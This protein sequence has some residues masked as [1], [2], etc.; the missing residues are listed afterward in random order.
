[1]EKCSFLDAVKTLAKQAGIEME[2]MS[3]EERKE[4]DMR[5]ALYELYERI[6]KTFHFFLTSDSLGKSAREYLEKRHGDASGT[7]TRSFADAFRP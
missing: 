1:M 5:E 7:G 2:E 3:P 4:N 6:S